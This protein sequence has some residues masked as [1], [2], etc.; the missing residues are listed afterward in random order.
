MRPTLSELLD[1]RGSFYAR[2]PAKGPM[3]ATTPLTEA[4][5]DVP[6]TDATP[7]SIG[8]DEAAPAHTGPIKLDWVQGVLVP[9]LLNIWGVIMFLRL[10][11]VAGQA[12]RP[13]RGRG[14][15]VQLRGRRAHGGGRQANI[16]HAGH[17]R[18]QAHRRKTRDQ[19]DLCPT[20]H[21]GTML[22]T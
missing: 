20:S 9:V 5:L 1:Q 6:S 17:E 19:G 21:C 22:E 18:R 11:W 2:S 8:E 16:G 10:G 14:A 12:G 3:G 4:P 13:R 7:H 15:L